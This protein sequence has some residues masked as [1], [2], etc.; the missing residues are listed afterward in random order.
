MTEPGLADLLS[1]REPEELL[2]QFAAW[3]A[4]GGRPLYPAQEEAVLLVLGIIGGVGGSVT[5]LCYS[6][7]LQEKQWRGAAFLRHTR[8]DLGVAAQRRA[9]LGRADSGRGSRS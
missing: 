6:Y 5:L 8:I 3:A 9:W 2:E 1:P 4:Q 7:W